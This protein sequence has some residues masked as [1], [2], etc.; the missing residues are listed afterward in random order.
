MSLNIKLVL[1]CGVFLGATTK[2]NELSFEETV[3]TALAND[4]WQ[5]G[6]ENKRLAMVARSNA[7]SV[8]PDPIIALD[9]VNLGSDNFAFNQ[10]PM[11]Q[12]KVGI[13][14]KFPRGDRLELV[15]RRLLQQSKQFPMLGLDRQARVK[16]AS[17]ETW[18]RA[19]QA[20]QTMRLIEQDRPLFE[21]LIEVAHRSYEAGQGRTLQSDL[22]SAEVELT[23]LDDRIATIEAKAQGYLQQLRRW[24][25]SERVL[26]PLSP[27][28]P[29]ISPLL[30]PNDDSEL[31]WANRLF[32][33]PAILAFDANQRAL[34]TDIEL[35]AQHKKVQWEVNGSYGLRANAPDGS[36]RSDLFS[37]GVKFDLP[38]FS[39]YKHHQHIMAAKATA[40]I[41][42]TDKLLMIRQM[43][44]DALSLKAQLT[45]LK[46]RT[47]LYKTKLLPQTRQQVAAALVAYRNESGDFSH[48]I[49]AR[50]S[51][52]NRRIEAFNITI[53]QQIA[54]LKLNYFLTVVNTGV[55]HE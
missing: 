18:L 48:V 34:D 28:L 16:V 20:Q 17:G 23:A 22:I 13:S 8:L 1:F 29:V 5:Q 53:E 49:L 44:G 15:Q 51:E 21:Q 32:T 38:M 42:K 2:A 10:E 33:H 40:Q 30:L 41:V 4:V 24:L 19:Y 25:P 9:L 54:T 7:A 11:T 35:A 14:Q 55:T 36:A 47:L 12:F 27:N 52:L 26:R 39:H 43:R 45:V 50:V 31:T 46:R 3:N 37:V 6:N